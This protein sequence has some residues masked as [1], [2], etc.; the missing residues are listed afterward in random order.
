M[1]PS[2]GCPRAGHSGLW[3][4]WACGS[5]GD[6]PGARFGDHARRDARWTRA[7]QAPTSPTTAP[8]G[9]TSRMAVNPN[10]MIIPFASPPH[11]PTKIRYHLVLLRYEIAMTPA[12]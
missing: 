5:M 8:W 6:P 3:Q 4:D 11:D 10:A 1:L 9:A 2:P 12:K 7:F